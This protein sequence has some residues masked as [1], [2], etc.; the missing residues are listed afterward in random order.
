M[1]SD[2]ARRA[3][4]ICG[5][6]PVLPSGRMQSNLHARLGIL[7]LQ[8]LAPPPM[9]VPLPPVDPLNVSLANFVRQ[10]LD[11]RIQRRPAPR[12]LAT[13]RG[14]LP[15]RSLYRGRWQALR[16]QRQDSQP[17]RQVV[18]GELG[19]SL[20]RFVQC[21]R[22]FLSGYIP[23]TRPAYKQV[24]EGRR[25]IAFVPPCRHIFAL[26]GKTEADRTPSAPPLHLSVAVELQLPKRTPVSGVESF[27]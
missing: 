15:P 19:V 18:A 5:M 23:D 16:V 20:P 9:P 27:R 14:K 21:S 6:P 3:A 11:Q 1:T 4:T 12:P 26:S 22:S 24:G 7:L 13:S 8:V 10:G 25:R 17:C 2:R